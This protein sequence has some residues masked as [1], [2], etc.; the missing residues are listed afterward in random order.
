MD[1]RVL[2]SK[3]GAIQQLSMS[4]IILETALGS[5]LQLKK[6]TEKT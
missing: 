5:G 4:K 6:L 1:R 3:T 2:G